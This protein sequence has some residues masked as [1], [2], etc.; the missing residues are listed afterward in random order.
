MTSPSSTWRYLS[1][2]QYHTSIPSFNVL[3]D[4]IFG[5]FLEV[6]TSTL[7]DLLFIFFQLLRAVVLRIL[8]RS[9]WLCSLLPVSWGIENG[10]FWASYAWT[11]VLF[12]ILWFCYLFEDLPSSLLL[13]E[14]LDLKADWK[15]YCCFINRIFKFFI[16]PLNIMV[17]DTFLY[18]FPTVVNLEKYHRFHTAGIFYIRKKM[19]AEF[20]LISYHCNLSCGIP[21]PCTK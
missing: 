7:F 5:F 10:G 11:G 15:C 17:M 3:V 9:G 13:F 6:I 18:F 4:Y 16:S 1:L 12:V 8:I 20:E 21:H 2:N 14:V 19:T